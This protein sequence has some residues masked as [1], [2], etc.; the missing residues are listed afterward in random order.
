MCY[1][2][3]MVERFRGHLEGPQFKWDGLW[4]G[5][6]RVQMRESLKQFIRQDPELSEYLNQINFNEIRRILS[7]RLRK[8][9]GG[10]AKEA[11]IVPKESVIFSDGQG[12]RKVGFSEDNAMTYAP[13]VELILVNLDNIHAVMQSVN[14]PRP[15]VFLY[16]LS[17][18]QGHAASSHHFSSMRK[19]RVGQIGLE[20]V[21]AREGKGKPVNFFHLLSEGVNDK[22]ARENVAT[23]LRSNPMSGITNADVEDLL[24]I[25]SSRRQKL[26]ILTPAH[27][28][29]AL[30]AN[31]A[32]SQNIDP[33]V[34]WESLI[35]AQMNG[36]DLLHPE[37]QKM[38]E[39]EIGEGFLDKIAHADEADIMEA[40]KKYRLTEHFDVYIR[41]VNRALR[42]SVG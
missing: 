34:V 36:L 38:L 35:H 13:E 25:Y 8:S 26:A 12:V 19:G 21:Y 2:L 42:R 9:T 18:E 28:V 15:L 11:H 40:L 5:K 20:Q 7:E 16:Y 4:S 37:N 39:S 29:E 1:I 27:L 30:V 41:A 14:F 23:Y 10:K 3:D 33:K 31:L 32:K 6:E 24:N 22:M 17:H